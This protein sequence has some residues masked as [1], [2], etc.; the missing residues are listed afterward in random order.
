MDAYDSVHPRAEGT[1][2]E[3]AAHCIT[4]IRLVRERRLIKGEKLVCAKPIVQHL[5]GCDRQ[6]LTS[7]H[8]A[9]AVRAVQMRGQSADNGPTRWRVE[10]LK[11]MMVVVE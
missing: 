1:A 6:V 8:S 11:A 4:Y 10:V 7:G 9:V 5:S 2:E 3:R